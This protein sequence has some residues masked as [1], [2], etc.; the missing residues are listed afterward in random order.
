MQA[1]I[2]NDISNV[3]V[4]SSANNKTEDKSNDVNQSAKS[5]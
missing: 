3:S 5:D 2:N 4:S 1:D